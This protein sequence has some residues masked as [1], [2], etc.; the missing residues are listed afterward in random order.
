VRDGVLTP[1]NL[2]VRRA[3]VITAV[4][5]AGLLVLAALSA[6]RGQELVL[7]IESANA[8]ERA[9]RQAA[10]G[11]L[12]SAASEYYR[13]L[14]LQHHDTNARAA[15]VE[16]Q[17]RRGLNVEALQEARILLEQ[18]QS[19]NRARDLALYGAAL[20]S[21]DQ[22]DAAARAFTEA[23]ELQPGLPDA[24]YGL[25]ILAGLRGNADLAREHFE[26]L[27]A[28]GLA[29]ASREFTAGMENGKTLSA[30]F[31]SRTEGP[32]L[33]PS[34]SAALVEW[35]LKHGLLEDALAVYRATPKWEAGD[36]QRPAVLALGR[37]AEGNTH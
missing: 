6:L 19:A 1:A 31:R 33:T 23:L 32:V 5:L 36:S 34:E 21:T 3:L 20:I 12:G 16:L 11:Q 25:G 2:L 28:S 10:R 14:E 4:A 35:Y 9:Q 29:H 18:P 13:Q 37:I 15:L 30:Q 22:R 26:Q 27:R 24:V 8:Y 7:A 17:L